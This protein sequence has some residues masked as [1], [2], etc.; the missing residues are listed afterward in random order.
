MEGDVM[1]FT[2]GVYYD[3]PDADYHAIK[4]MS[5]SQLRRLNKSPLHFRNIPEE[6]EP[7]RFGT[8]AHLAVLEPHRLD[9]YVVIP[10][11]RHNGK[12]DIKFVRSG[13]HWEEFQ[14]ANAS[15][16]GF[17]TV[18]EMADAK[19][20]SESVNANPSVRAI[21]Q[22]NHEVMLLWNDPLF[23][24]SKARIDV[25][26]SGF[27]TDLKTAAEVSPW[28]FDRACR[29]YG[30][31]IQ[32]AWYLRGMEACDVGDKHTLFKFAAVESKSPFDCAAY[33]CDAIFIKE[34]LDTIHG[35][36]VILGEC[37]AS[38]VWPGAWPEEQILTWTYFDDERELMFSEGEGDGMATD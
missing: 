9:S 16:A 1:N 14:A 29:R 19:R 30:Y 22:G 23:G 12:D 37:E 31:H 27:A 10:E 18:K 20:I 4:A 7:Q 36:G 38:G 3:I 11:T 21:L 15:A 8:L 6:T 28:G 13:K 32:A 33:R 5:A 34:G 24:P 17:V 35:C 2:P 25:L 26:G